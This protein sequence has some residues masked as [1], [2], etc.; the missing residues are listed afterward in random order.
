MKFFY[1]NP[2]MLEQDSKFFL[3]PDSAIGAVIS[4]E[5]FRDSGRNRYLR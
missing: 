4:G 3:Y 1:E 5:A 2:D